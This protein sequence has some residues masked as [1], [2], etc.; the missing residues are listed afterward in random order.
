[1]NQPG[2]PI[3]LS[4]EVFE[5]LDS[6]EKLTFIDSGIQ[7]LPTNVLCPLRYVQVRF[8]KK[9]QAGRQMKKIEFSRKIWNL[10]KN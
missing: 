8:P 9:D 1:M 7:Q 10:H 4:E 2:Q 5:P 3:Q 6:L